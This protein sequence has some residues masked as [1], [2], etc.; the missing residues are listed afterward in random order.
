M[1][2]EINKNEVKEFNTWAWVM[3][4]LMLIMIIS[5]VPLFSAGPIGIVIWAAIV[6]VTLAVCVKVEK[7]KKSYNIQTYKEISA[8][9]DGKP[10]D[11]I[12]AERKKYTTFQK[13][14]FGVFSGIVAFG[15]S[16]GIMWLMNK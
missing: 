7:L 6:A 16:F 3:T 12:E 5:P 9:M 10:L 15:I 4:G 11:E 8:F 2:N 1:K 13:V 14:M